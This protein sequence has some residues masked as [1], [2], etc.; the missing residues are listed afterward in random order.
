MIKGQHFTEQNA[1]D[2]YRQRCAELENEVDRLR[3]ALATIADYK[4]DDKDHII[5]MPVRVAYKALGM[6]YY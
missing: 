3:T 2:H 6:E 5:N 4:V 1:I